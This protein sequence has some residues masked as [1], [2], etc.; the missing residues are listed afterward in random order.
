MRALELLQPRLR[1]RASYARHGW[2]WRWHERGA[3]TLLRLEYG[4]AFV[5][6]AQPPTA[7]HEM[8]MRR[9][10]ELLARLAQARRGEGLSAD[11]AAATERLLREE[12]TDK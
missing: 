5:R 12:G 9:R 3:K 8:H 4:R 7:E 11:P 10:Q 6:A 1:A 2:A